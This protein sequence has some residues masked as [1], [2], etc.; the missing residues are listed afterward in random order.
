M[1]EKDI[2]LTAVKTSWGLCEWVFMPMGLTNALA[3]QQR[4]CEEALRDLVNKVCVIYFDDTYCEFFA[5]CGE[6]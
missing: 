3:T 2:P 4:Q 6:A 1:E 5:V